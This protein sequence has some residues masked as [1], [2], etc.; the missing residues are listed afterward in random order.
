MKF[1]ICCCSKDH[2]SD[3]VRIDH[4]EDL[5]VFP[6]QILFP[7]ELGLVHILDEVTLGTSVHLHQLVLAG[8]HVVVVGVEQGGVLLQELLAVV[9]LP[10]MANSSSSTPILDI[11][12]LT[13]SAV[14]L[15]PV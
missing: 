8:H 12:S 1:K 7:L 15:T 6:A 10:F 3:G 5:N 2:Q 9:T 13:S 14:L 4:G 11:C